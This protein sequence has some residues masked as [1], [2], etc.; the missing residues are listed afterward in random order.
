MAE[1]R[2]GYTTG[3][4]A[5]ACAHAAARF[6]AIG[7]KLCA[8]EL[9]L[10]G[11]G[12]RTI[13][14]SFSSCGENWAEFAAIKD[15]GDDPDATNGMRVLTKLAI[16]RESEGEISFFAGE[17]VGTVTKNGLKIPPGQPAINP[18]P[19][20]MI[21]REARLYLGKCAI[22]ATVSIPG[23]KEVAARTFNPR[24]GI[25]G[26]LSVL[27]T[28][29]IVRPMSSQAIIDTTRA[30]LDVK[31]AAGYDDII[32]VF[33]AMGEEALIKRGYDAD[34]MVQ[35][36]NFV[37]EA[38]DYTAKLGFKCILLAG[39]AGKLIKLSAG[40]F[41]THSAIA[42]ARA[43]IVCAQ[44]AMLGAPQELILELYA[45]PTTDA[46]AAALERSGYSHVWQALCR[47]SAEKAS[48]RAGIPVECVII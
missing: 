21:E 35:M 40:I 44:A 2:E 31:K 36:S 33:G 6:L 41:N 27:G 1:L 4:C 23:G 42:D 30:E 24:L 48:I 38:L 18:I 7:E 47:R 8:V 26:G 34:K 3:S 12:T 10:P 45:C 5:A 17:G 15:A 22:D 14:V 46:M 19:R 11:G 39:H 28:T 16:H 29:G 9:T 43:E 13:E 32:L 37:G 25:E 20:S